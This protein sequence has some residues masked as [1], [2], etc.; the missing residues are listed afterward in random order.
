MQVEVISDQDYLPSLFGLGLSH[1]LTS[2]MRFANFIK[3][4]N[5]VARVIDV[6]LRLYNKD[7]GHNKFLETMS[8][9]LHVS[10]PRFW[11]QEADTYRISTKQSEST[12]HTI[13][14]RKLN[15]KDFS[16][17]ISESHLDF[18]NSLLTTHFLE[19]ERAK[20]G[21]DNKEIL[22]T[23]FNQ[24]KANLSEG[25]IQSRVWKVSYKTLKEIILQ[26]KNHK[27]T[28][29]RDFVAQVKIKVNHPEYLAASEAR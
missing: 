13:T 19:K 25:F 12:I 9:V 11:W 17:P 26:R 28:E 5:L 4:E 29:W 10:A 16:S 15:Q 8:V 6:S 27:L 22:N 20:A 1:G 18:L 7:H 2:E 23:L 3:D 21:I 14:K 24:I